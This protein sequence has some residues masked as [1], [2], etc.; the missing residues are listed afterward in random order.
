MLALMGPLNVV[1]SAELANGSAN[2]GPMVRA[3]MPAV[4]FEQD[5][6]VYFDIHHTPDDTLNKVVPAELAQNVAAW[7]IFV[8]I[9]A[10]W[11]GRFERKI[12]GKDVTSAVLRATSK[13]KNVELLQVGKHQP[14][15]NVFSG[16]GLFEVRHSSLDAR[17]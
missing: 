3:G 15:L 7:V 1:R 17:G 8:K 5:H 10:D 12:N 4:G 11:E 13:T 9:A 14:L 2:F 6:S 16:G